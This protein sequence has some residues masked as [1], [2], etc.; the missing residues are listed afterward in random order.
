MKALWRKWSARYAASSPRE[1][2]LIAVAILAAVGFALYTAWVEPA[3]KRAGLLRTQID[4]QRGE[5]AALTAQLDGLKSQLR[6]P[7]AG[8]RQALADLKARL[9][10]VDGEIGRLDDKL[11]PP[12][13]MARLLQT[14][15]ARHRGLHLVS[16]RSLPPEPLL[17]P[18]KAEKDAEGKE[19]AAPGENIYRHAVEVKLAGGY[20]DLLA[21]VAELERAPQP[22]MRGALTLTATEYPRCELTLTVHTLSREK[23]WLS[24]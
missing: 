19:A 24:V 20:A 5:L 4:Q 1:Q 3:A 17:A 10:A 8:N 16:L 7:D 11:V 14:L 9:A 22:L 6:D 18:P 21:Y 15:L 13:R 12:Q 23:D 2:L